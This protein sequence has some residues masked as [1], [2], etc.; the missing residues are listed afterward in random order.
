MP[1]ERDKA[2]AAKI[3]AAFDGAI[4]TQRA[5]LQN[6]YTQL[7]SDA[8]G[9]T[10]TLSDTAS[11]MASHKSA[12]ARLLFGV[13]T[14]LAEEDI[15]TNPAHEGIR[16]QFAAPADRPAYQQALVESAPYRT[17]IRRTYVVCGLRAS[18][19]AIS[20]RSVV[21]R[22]LATYAQNSL[23]LEWQQFGFD[24][25]AILNQLRTSPRS[26]ARNSS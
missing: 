22:R 1:D 6:R 23:S 13:S 18:L 15:L 24:H 12:I 7:F 4:E 26:S 16:K 10:Q 3:D 17:L 5:T 20:D 25:E 8:M 19:D 11:S 21:L 9:T 2:A 14:F